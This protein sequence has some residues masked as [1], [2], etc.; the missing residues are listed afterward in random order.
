MSTYGRFVTFTTQ[1]GKADDLVA[2]LVQASAMTL[3]LENCRQ[4]TVSKDVNEPN[5]IH[6][7]EVWDSKADADH[8]LDNPEA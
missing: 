6:I 3:L 5:Y 7:F 2:L 4:Y 1:P 8:S